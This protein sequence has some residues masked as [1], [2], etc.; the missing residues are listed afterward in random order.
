[1]SEAPKPVADLQHIQKAWDGLIVSSLVTK[2]LS[3]ASSEVDKARLLAASAPHSGD[4][5]F[6]PQISSVGLELSDEAIRMSA[7]QRLG[8]RAC[9]PQTCLCGKTVDA[10]G[11]HGLACRKSAPRHQRHSQMNDLIW[12]AVKRA[13]IPAVKEPVGLMQ[14]GKRPDGAILI[15]WARGKPLA[16]DVTVPDTYADSHIHDTAIQAGAA[17]DRAAINKCAKYRPW[18]IHTSSFPSP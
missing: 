6:A 14:D 1:M 5:L 17:A 15:P 2:V 10:R 8:C 11:L 16:W 7:A 4:W 3:R 13:E 18:K 9:E 12:R